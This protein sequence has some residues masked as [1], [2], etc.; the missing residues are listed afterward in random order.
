MDASSLGSKMPFSSAENQIS[1]LSDI[2]TATNCI[3]EVGQRD[4]FVCLQLNDPRVQQECLRALSSDPNFNNAVA[5]MQS[6]VRMPF[7]HASVSWEG[8]S[9]CSLFVPWKREWEHSFAYA[10]KGV[11]AMVG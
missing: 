6:E 1:P 3:F 7:A 2:A 5:N 9:P 8:A 10:V 11:V 4:G